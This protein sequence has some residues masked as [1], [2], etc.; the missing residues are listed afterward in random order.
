MYKRKKGS[1]MKEKG[2]KRKNEEK[3][4]VKRPK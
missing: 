4:K 1:T 3:M 2:R